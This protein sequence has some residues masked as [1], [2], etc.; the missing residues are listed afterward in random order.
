MIRIEKRAIRP[1]SVENL[2]A[3]MDA[4]PIVLPC[5]I[6]GGVRTRII[7]LVMV[8]SVD[9]YIGLLDRVQA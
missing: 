7:S 4:L 2:A 9:K 3:P 8:Q 1:P 5:S 6:K